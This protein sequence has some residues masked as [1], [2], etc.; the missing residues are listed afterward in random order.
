M[1]RN[2]RH[3]VEVSRRPTSPARASPARDPDLHAIL[4]PSWNPDLDLPV[5]AYPAVAAADRARLLDDPAFPP[6][7]GTRRR[8][9]EKPLVPALHASTPTL[10]TRQRRSSGPPPCPCTR[11]TSPR[12]A[13]QPASL[14]LSRHR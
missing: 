5:P 8:E 1:L 12:Q 7:P 4:C 11:R 10:R 14:H 3:D 9:R 2:P 13:H 6:T